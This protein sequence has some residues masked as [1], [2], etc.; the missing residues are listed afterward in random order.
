VALRRA[1]LLHSKLCAAHAASKSLLVLHPSSLLVPI[2]SL[3]RSASTARLCCLQRAAH[4]RSST[5]SSRRYQ[6]HAITAAA[7]AIMYS[8]LGPRAGERLRYLHCQGAEAQSDWRRVGAKFS[9]Q[10]IEFMCPSVRGPDN[11]PCDGETW[12]LG[13]ATGRW[14]VLPEHGGWRERH[15][16]DGVQV[17]VG[18]CSIEGAKRNRRK[19]RVVRRVSQM[20]SDCFCC[21]V[22]CR[23]QGASQSQQRTEPKHLSKTS[24]RSCRK[25]NTHNYRLQLTDASA[26]TP[27]TGQAV[28]R[29]KH[30]QQ[31]KLLSTN[32]KRIRRSAPHNK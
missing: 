32:L 2:H 16:D 15:C 5:P 13:V 17:V 7:P 22:D 24:G 8:P 11:A 14:H 29:R 19:A 27:R 28:L 30:T 4:L 12:R 3:A 10:T 25:N 9:P 21:A 23:L 31:R 18:T 26:R 6:P 20:D 1:P